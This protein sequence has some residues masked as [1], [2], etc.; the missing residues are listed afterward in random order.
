MA[1]SHRLLIVSNRLPFRAHVEE[2]EVVLT[3]STGGVASGLRVLH[4]E[5]N[6]LWIGWPGD[7]SSMPRR[8]RTIVRAHMRNHHIVPVNLTR[9]ESQEYYDGFCN[10]ILWPLLH[11]QIDRLPLRA[12]E[13]RTYRQVNERFAD[14]I[15][16]HYRPGDRIWIHD[17]HL[18]LVP[19]LLRSYVPDAEIGF[20]L[21]V[22]FPAAD[23][24]R[25]LPWRHEMLQ[26]LLGATLVGFHTGGYAAH[27]L[28]TVRSLTAL[29]VDGSLIKGASRS[30][31]VG[32]YPMGADVA[33]FG[34]MAGSPFG[35][36]T[37]T[38]QTRTAQA[39]AD[40]PGP[41]DQQILLGVDRLDYT[42]GIPR[43]LLAYE[44]LLQDHPELRGRV[45]MIQIGV[46][47]RVGVPSYERYREQVE[48]L[49]SR[50][51]GEMG[52][53]G[54]TPIEYLYQ[55]VSPTQLASLYRAADVMVVT[56]LRDG[57]NLVA[58]EYV[59]ARTD[60]DGVLVLSEFAGSAHELQEALIVNPYAIDEMAEAFARA[61]AMSA[62][63]RRQRMEALR[64]K[65]LARDVRWWAS[66]FMRD[67]TT[68]QPIASIDQGATSR[69]CA[70]PLERAVGVG[71]SIGSR[72][73]AIA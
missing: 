5:T 17:F 12:P 57:M 29:E 70:R 32:V 50:I 51:N 48:E 27:F 43:R 19:G 35:A 3:P 61:L 25:I 49:V 39:R 22:P 14:A 33:G 53:V 67:L 20:F 15:A 13:W 73:I 31:R 56:P 47:S 52:R 9:S 38:A 58:K 36:Q 6:S 59:A 54:W 30:V 16:E 62:S 68:S 37:R 65:V 41:P 40:I 45:R 42:K 69:A 1:E 55:S 64:K 4:N 34:R 18:M 44:R 72:A 71:A 2:E 60:H 63:E 11:Y 7:L 26:G 28:D 66:T 10:G 21:H 8:H 23:I 24:F 46:P